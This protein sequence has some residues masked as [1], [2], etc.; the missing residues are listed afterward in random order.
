M[1][2]TVPVTAS[3]SAATVGLSVALAAVPWFTVQ[4]TVVAE[5]NSPP[6]RVMV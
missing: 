1:K 4:V 6:S 5:G 3:K 2:S